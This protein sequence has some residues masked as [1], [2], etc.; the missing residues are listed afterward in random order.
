[1]MKKRKEKIS[2]GEKDREYAFNLQRQL[3][4]SPPGGN[5][6]ALKDL[7]LEANRLATLE[8][9]QARQKSQNFMA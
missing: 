3:D 4:T 2:E 9:S 5:I 1:M 8:E 7:Q 6:Q